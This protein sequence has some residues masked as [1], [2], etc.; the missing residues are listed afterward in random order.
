M[1]PQLFLRDANAEP[2]AL[3]HPE[4]GPVEQAGPEAR[5][6]LETRAHGATLRAREHDG[7]PR[8]A[9]CAHDVV[10][11]REIEDEAPGP[12]DVR[13]LGAAAHGAGSPGL[14][15]PVERGWGGPARPVSR[16]TRTGATTGSDPLTRV[17]DPPARAKRDHSHGP[18]CWPA[19]HSPPAPG[20]QGQLRCARSATDQTGARGIPDP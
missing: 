1:S 20:T 13:L 12:G 3:E 18:L 19:Q 5:H 15:D 14:A 2:A 4:P 6:A 8:G 17:Q 11:P 10:E 7:K 9:L 16:A